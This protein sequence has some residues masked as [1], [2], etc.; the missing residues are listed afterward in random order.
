MTI[1]NNLIPTL[2]YINCDIFRIHILLIAYLYNLNNNLYLR[3]VDMSKAVFFDRDGVINI[4]SNYVY[5]IQDF[6]FY[7]DFFEIALYFKQKDYKL[8]VITNQS[9]IQRGYYNIMDFLKLSKYMQNEIFKKLGFY[10]DRIYFCP[11]IDDTVKRKPAPGMILQAQQDFL[12][13]LTTCYLVG[14]K[15]S[16]IEAGINAG[17]PHLFLLKRKTH[18]NYTKQE[19]TESTDNHNSNI[20]KFYISIQNKNYLYYCIAT[21]RDMCYNIKPS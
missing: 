4:D 20:Q 18:Q 14:D 8:I 7:E 1:R 17:I 16:D 11:S 2:K 12:L 9:G 19:Y 10:L 15:M 3:I 21:L 6:L 13:N 5:K